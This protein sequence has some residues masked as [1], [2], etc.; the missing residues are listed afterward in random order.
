MP[1]KPNHISLS[2]QQIGNAGN[3][4]NYVQ[5]TVGMGGQPAVVNP[6]PAPANPPAYTPSAQ[7]QVTTAEFQVS[8]GSRNVC[9]VKS[10]LHPAIQSPTGGCQSL[11]TVCEPSGRCSTGSF[12]PD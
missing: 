1:L 2:L 4:P 5:P 8:W 7:Q 3:P 12:M 6:T 9:Q 10:K 11:L